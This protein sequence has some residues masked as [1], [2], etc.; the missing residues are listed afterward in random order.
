MAGAFSSL[1]LMNSIANMG[2]AGEDTSRIEK[3]AGEAIIEEGEEGQVMFFVESGQA[4]IIVKGRTIE[5]VDAGGIIGEMA[6]ID[7]ATR[8]ANVIAT[9]DC[10]LIPI[11]R[12]L[13]VN[14]VKKN[15]LF[16]LYVMSV[17]NQRLRA[18]SEN[19]GN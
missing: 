4:N 8:S 19:F 5:T 15:P 11:G 12:Q 18:A 7:T 13:F 6:L 10:C 17:M 14:L 9:T 3:K 2:I 1:E 16:S